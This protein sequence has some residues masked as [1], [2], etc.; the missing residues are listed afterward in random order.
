ML[1][2]PSEK[3]STVQPP[4]Q[5]PSTLA[6]LRNF[7]RPITAEPTAQKI[8][9]N[10]LKKPPIPSPCRS[11]ELR[12]EITERLKV[13]TF[14]EIIE[15]EKSS[16]ALKSFAIK[17]NISAWTE[18]FNAKTLSPV[19]ESIISNTVDP[20]CIPKLLNSRQCNTRTVLSIAE[21]NTRNEVYDPSYLAKLN[22]RFHARKMLQLEEEPDKTVTNELSSQMMGSSNMDLSPTAS[23]SFM[24]FYDEIE[25]RYELVKDS[26]QT[27]MFGLNSSLQVN[28]TPLK[29]ITPLKATTS[30]KSSTPLRSSTPLKSKNRSVGSV[31]DSPLLRA[32]EKCKSLNE[33]KKKKER[34]VWTLTEALAFLGLK[35]VTD[36]FADPLED[37]EMEA[38]EEV[39]KISANPNLASECPD[40]DKTIVSEHKDIPSTSATNQVSQ[41]TVSQILQIVNVSHEERDRDRPENNISNVTNKSEGKEIYIGTID[42]IF[43]FDDNGEM[44]SAVPSDKQSASEEDVIA[45]SQPVIPEIKL[46]SK[47]LNNNSRTSN[48]SEFAPSGDDMFASFLKGNSSVTSTSSNNSNNVLSKT[49]N[50][51]LM[52]PA[53][54]L[55]RA[56]NATQPKT[57]S[58]SPNK[59]TLQVVD[60][61]PSVFKRRVNLSRLRALST[62]SNSERIPSNA[63]QNKS[64][65]FFSCNNFDVNHSKRNDDFPTRIHE[66][67]SDN[68]SQIG[69]YRLIICMASLVRPTNEIS[70]SLSVGRRS[71]I[72]KISS[73]CLKITKRVYS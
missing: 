41:Y 45:S 25:S 64:P 12:L 35:D 8:Q 72:F 2:V 23:E 39:V 3:R 30:L 13:P 56:V 33:S 21:F 18:K 66:E 6:D 47:Y 4:R 57:K 59:S 19:Y 29:A 65:L 53:V 11:T 37:E 5:R 9:L 50:L 38:E 54:E 28:G 20:A 62:K 73:K 58:P 69:E 10:E 7:F 40:V 68:S 70:F 48:H 46:P 1:Q 51:P 36:I 31:K 43:G 27:K 60:K 63:L 42:E 49:T 15:D 26:N 71:K 44:D 32:F 16:G 55:H 34:K 17:M 67:D 24:P 52:R 61:S 14:W 22:E